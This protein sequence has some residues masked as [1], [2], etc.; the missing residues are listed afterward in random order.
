MTT[1][2][3]VRWLALGLMLV[4]GLVFTGIHVDI[5]A[6]LAHLGEALG[7]IATRIAGL[8]AGVLALAKM[9]QEALGLL[10]REFPMDD[11]AVHT[12]DRGG[13]RPG[14]WERVL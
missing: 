5:P 13:A 10:N 7:H 1:L 2:P 4:F 8:A 14:F 3:R 6:L 9:I 11:T 12:M